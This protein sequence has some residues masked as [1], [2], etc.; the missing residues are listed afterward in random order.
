MWSLSL[1][2]PVRRDILPVFS[3][4]SVGE[5]GVACAGALLDSE[6]WLE[7]SAGWP[8]ATL[9]MSSNDSISQH[10]R[11]LDGANIRMLDGLS[12]VASHLGMRIL[13]RGVVN[14]VLR[15]C[16]SAFVEDIIDRAADWW[17]RV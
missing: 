5:A 13:D 6:W 4:C 8:G 3:S 15:T 12:V 9:A 7:A 1:S 10:S 14:R 17:L 2:F 11:T 16:G